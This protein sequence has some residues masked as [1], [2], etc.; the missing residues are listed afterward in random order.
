[1]QYKT[2]LKKL[3][4]AKRISQQRLAEMLNTSQSRVSAYVL[5]KEKPNESRVQVMRSMLSSR[6]YFKRIKNEIGNT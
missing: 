2:N 6:L 1:M 3:L 4:W 5:G